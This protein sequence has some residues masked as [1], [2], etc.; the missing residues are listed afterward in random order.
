M[1]SN[2][3]SNLI[4]AEYT[5]AKASVIFPQPKA[6]FPHWLFLMPQSPSSFTA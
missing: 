3:I 5:I 1:K 6:E 2:A 4:N